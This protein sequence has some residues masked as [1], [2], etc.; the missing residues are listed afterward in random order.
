VKGDRRN[1][2]TSICSYSKYL[3]AS[4]MTDIVRRQ[5]Q[6]ASSSSSSLLQA[7]AAAAEEEP[8]GLSHSWT[9]GWMPYVLQVLVLVLVL[10]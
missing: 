1:E 10:Y 5:Q 9:S 8:C 4:S 2:V 6:Q 3:A 7:A